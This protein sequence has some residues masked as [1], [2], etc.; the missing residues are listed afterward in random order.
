MFGNEC[1]G[2]LKYEAT[3]SSILMAGLF[4][5]F[6]VEYGGHRLVSAKI[7][8]SAALSQTEKT[9]AFLSAEVVSILVMEAGI[10]FHSLRKLFPLRRYTENMKLTI[11][12]H[13]PY[14]GRCRR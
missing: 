12:S 8:R 1:L 2:E 4:L 6:L 7:K 13:R 5:S 9:N 10:V 11:P 14:A 3:T